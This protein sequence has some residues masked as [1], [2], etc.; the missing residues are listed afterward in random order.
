[1]NYI[2][3]L[4]L[5][6]LGVINFLSHGMEVAPNLRIKKVANIRLL[7]AAAMGN[8]AE[9][10]QLIMQNIADVNTQNINQCTP[11][12]LAC[13]NNH[14]TVAL[15]LIAAGADVNSVDGI[16]ETALVCAVKNKNAQLVYALINTNANV[17]VRNEDGNNILNLAVRSHI[18]EIVKALIDN[19]STQKEGALLLAAYTYY[20][21]NNCHYDSD[22][23]RRLNGI[24][25]DIVNFLIKAGADLNVQ[26]QK[27]DYTPLIIA[28]YKNNTEIALT[29]IEAGADVNSI[30]KE[31]D[32]ALVC[33]VENENCTLLASL[34]KAGAEVNIYD[35]YGVAA[36]TLAIKS[37]LPEIS[38]ALMNPVAKD[39][40][41]KKIEMILMIY[42]KRCSWLSVLPQEILKIVF[43]CAYPEF[44]LDSQF[45]KEVHPQVLV[46]TIPLDTLALLINKGTL[47]QDSIL[48]NWEKKVTC[49]VQLLEA[50]KE[51]DNNVIQQF[52]TDALI[53]IVTSLT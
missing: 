37:G 8:S 47:N 30:D 20:T 32:T 6:V 31:G 7:H 36:L 40:V 18:I 41:R 12:H 15:A 24:Y 29:L 33:A 48:E 43:T 19:G 27:K 5:S 13:A 50:Q 1:M 51:L 39:T 28:C 35:Q 11:L 21:S 9:V 4:V 52:A 42:Y 16:G 14:T 46:N 17:N 22:E 3:V 34:V 2:S 53:K 10:K 23:I 49:I 25:L 44:V 26:T 45:I 38:M